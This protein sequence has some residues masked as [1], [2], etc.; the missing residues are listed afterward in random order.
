MKSLKCAPGL[1]TG[2]TISRARDE[3]C[4]Q[5]FVSFIRMAFDLLSHGE[6]LLMNPHIEAMAYHLEQVRLGTITRLMINLPPR[7][8]KSLVT[9]VAFPAFVL[10][11]DPTKRLNVA[12]YG[13]DL[14]VKLANDC[15]SV[16]LFPRYKSIFPGLQISRMK[17]TEAEI[18]TTRGGFRLATSVDGSITGRGGDI[19]I[20]DDP[21]KPSDACSDAKRNHVNTWSRGWMTSK[22][23]RSL[24]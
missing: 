18:T 3:A 17:N 10:G 13:S 11:H 2:L 6:P 12:S 20:I 7:Y 22:K 8:L 5:D 14:A 16:I 19:L 23:A 9:S 24:S 4:R 1:P 21:L 15:R